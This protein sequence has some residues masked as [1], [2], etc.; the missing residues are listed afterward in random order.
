M[1]KKVKK[2]VYF[3]SFYSGTGYV[4]RLLYRSALKNP[5][6]ILYAHRLVDEDDELFWLYRRLGY[7]TPA[8]FENKIRYLKKRY[9]VISLK[10]CCRFLR[11]GDMPPN[12][13]VLTFDDGY[14]CN[15]RTVFPVLVKYGVPATV[16]LSYNFI[17]NRDI[18]WYDKVMFAIGKTR[19]KSFLM[20]DL[21]GERL[22]LETGEERVE[23]LSEINYLLKSLADDEKER[24]IAGILRSLRIGAKKLDSAELMLTWEDVR[25]MRDSGLVS[26]GSHTLSHPLLTRVSPDRA[27]DEINRSKQLIEE[28]LGET[29]EFFSYPCG[30]QNKLLKSFVREARYNCALTTK[31]GGNTLST[32]LFELRRDGFISSPMYMFGLKMAGFFEICGALRHA[33]GERV[34]Q[35]EEVPEIVLGGG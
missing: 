28:R 24:V 18:P 35:V 33:D 4:I 10:E 12:C 26:F 19:V 23:A 1:M 27:Q 8:E 11:S 5:V 34:N 14:K 22:S 7:M 15:R 29:V 16:F 3:L 25:E 30:R 31:N 9:N 17:E 32:D 2:L 20:K 13:A 21:G 6:K